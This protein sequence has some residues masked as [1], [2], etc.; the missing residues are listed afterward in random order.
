MSS[1]TSALKSIPK[2][3]TILRNK[4][5]HAQKYIKSEHSVLEIAVSEK[6]PGE[7]AGFINRLIRDKTKHTLL[8]AKDMK[9][10]VS[11][12]RNLAKADYSISTSVDN[13][14][15]VILV[16][17][18]SVLSLNALLT[19]LKSLRPDQ[20]PQVVIWEHPHMKENDALHDAIRQAVETL[21]LACHVR[22]RENVYV[23]GEAP[24]QFAYLENPP[25]PTI[26]HNVVALLAIFIIAYLV[27]ALMSYFLSS[28]TPTTKSLAKSPT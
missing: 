2:M 9:S 18:A 14:A 6:S 19:Y 10:T 21:G 7:F 4:V 8:I 11:H 25:R 15:D 3:P 27:Y 20:P 26:L 22:G 1:K 16:N 13:Q 28:T 5:V 17:H 24:A 23:L 12:L